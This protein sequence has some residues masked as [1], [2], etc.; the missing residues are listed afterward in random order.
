MHVCGNHSRARLL[1]INLNYSQ[2]YTPV[3]TRVL[4]LA[5]Y[6]QKHRCAKARRLVG[7]GRVESSV[8]REREEALNCLLYPELR[9]VHYMGKKG[10]RGRWL[11]KIGRVE[12]STTVAVASSFSALTGST[13]KRRFVFFLADCGM[14]S[15]RAVSRHKEDTEIASKPKRNRRPDSFSL[16][17]RRCDLHT[18]AC[19][20]ASNAVT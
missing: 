19:L 20:L 2:Y 15:W 17:L 11:V 1:P 18:H 12:I 5:F 3:Y 10:R 14:A 7:K 8:D 13:L 9:L 4:V 6:G 16:R